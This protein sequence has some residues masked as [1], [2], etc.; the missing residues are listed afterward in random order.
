MLWWVLQGCDPG[1]WAPSPQEA[2]GKGDPE[3][4]VKN[5]NVLLRWDALHTALRQVGPQA[6]AR[7]SVRRIPHACSALRLLYTAPGS[8]QSV[9]AC[10]AMPLPQIAEVGGDMQ[11]YWELWRTGRWWWHVHADRLEYGGDRR[12]VCSLPSTERRGTSV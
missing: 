10:C 6:A 9:N 4:W 11:Q 8:T 5:R 1:A 12:N 7:S 2:A 3:A